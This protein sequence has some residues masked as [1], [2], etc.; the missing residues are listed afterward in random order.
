MKLYATITSERATRG[1]GGK[2]LEISIFDDKEEKI[3]QLRVYYPQSSDNPMIVLEM[4]TKEI[5]QD[6]LTSSKIVLQSK[7]K[8]KKQKGECEHIKKNG[9]YFTGKCPICEH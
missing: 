7:T 2:E 4:A 9:A 5:A 1:Q 3:A 8:G 6:L